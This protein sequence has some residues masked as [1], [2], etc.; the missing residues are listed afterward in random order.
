[1]GTP[2]MSRSPLLDYLESLSLP[3]LVLSNSGLL[4]SPPIL[5][6][7]ALQKGI[8][9]SAFLSCLVPG[10]AEK[11]RRWIQEERWREEEAVEIILASSS[12]ART[13]RQLR[14]TGRKTMRTT[15][16][17]TLSHDSG[18][19]IVILTATTSDF[20]RRLDLSSDSYSSSTS[21]SPTPKSS[22]SPLLSPSDGLVI[23]PAER[24]K[25]L[26]LLLDLC[27]VGVARLDLSGK[28]IWV[29]KAWRD[30]ADHPSDLPLEEWPKNID[31]RDVKGLTEEWA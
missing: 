12:S 4:D 24:F 13:G 30:V 19:E 8:E 14:S 26:E 11:F 7:L 10:E 2:S 31:E 15:W 28:L 20:Q 27:S 5:G 6:N 18:Q 22:P 1:M 21:F 29:N 25:E 17:V 9:G 16:K 3:V 23:T